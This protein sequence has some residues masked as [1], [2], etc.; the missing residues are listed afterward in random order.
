ME[1]PQD[2]LSDVQL[3]RVSRFE[4]LRFSYPVALELALSGVDWHDAQA[5]LVSGAT[6]E[7]AA[8]IL[9]P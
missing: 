7:Q 5:L 9:L 4:E 2:E 3:Y 8:R 6:V 1:T